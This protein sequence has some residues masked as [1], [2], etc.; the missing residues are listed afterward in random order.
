MIIMNDTQHRLS[1]MLASEYGLSYKTMKS[2]ITLAKQLR[3]EAQHCVKLYPL[4]ATG[5]PSKTL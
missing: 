3:P 5:Q 2:S 4:Y 1:A